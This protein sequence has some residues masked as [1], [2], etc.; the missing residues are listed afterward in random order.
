MKDS[1]T[2]ERAFFLGNGIHRTENN[3]GIS[4]GK[5]LQKIS[6]TYGIN[7]DLKNELKPFPLAFEE[8]LYAKEGRSA[9]Q[10]KLRTLKAKI[11]D[12]LLEDVNSLIDNEIHKEFMQSGIKEIITT[13][14]DY[15]L[16][17]SI[18]DVFLINKKKY[19]IDNLESKHSLYRG[20]K[21]G[22]VTVR[23]IHGELKHNRNIE[24]T[25]K[26][27]PEESI[28]IG[29]EHYSDCF[30]K[31][32]SVIKGESGKHKES[33]K[34]SVLVR[35]RDNDTGK[36]WTDLFFTH[37]L[38]FAGFSLDFSENHLWWLLIQREELKRQS[39][40]FDVKINNEIIFCV[41]I[42]PIESFSYSISNEEDF[43]K[44]YHKKLSTDKNKG[45]TDI[46]NSLK[47][48]INPIK[49]NSYRDFYLKVIDEYSIK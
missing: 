30:S 1:Y 11:S 28:M 2:G 45:V 32:Q 15:S 34:K 24:V 35:L 46:L 48:I 20:Y 18:Q 4:W 5:L 12:I 39:Y 29:F 49:C 23:H 44:L 31:I 3:N 26:N 33:E 41:P 47:V 14:Y 9:F 37:Q 38:V 7:T 10:S 17:A 8:M 21:I 22:E 40:K 19:S 25:D 43:N 16:E 42:L 6:S 13:N 27:Y 36:M